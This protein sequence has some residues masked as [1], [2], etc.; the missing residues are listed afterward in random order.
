MSKIHFLFTMLNITQLTVINKGFMEG[1][2]TRKEFLQKRRAAKEIEMAPLSTT[3]E[4]SN[5]REP[6]VDQMMTNR[7]LSPRETAPK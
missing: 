1:I 2:I 4:E 5:V 3:S 6:L 7:S